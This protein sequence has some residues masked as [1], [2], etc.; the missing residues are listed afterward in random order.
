MDSD[1]AIRWKQ[2]LIYFK[3]A[4]YQLNLFLETVELN[5]MEEQGLIKSFEYNYELGWNLLK[6]YLEYQGDTQ[7]TGSRDALRKAYNRGLISDGDGWMNMIESRNKTTHTYS[8]VIV[9]EVLQ[10]IREEHYSLFKELNE[11]FSKLN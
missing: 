8:K 11:K 2:R 1:K 6:D 3:D 9:D 5:P 7:I 4:L 10:A